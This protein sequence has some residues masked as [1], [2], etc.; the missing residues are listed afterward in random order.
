[1]KKINN[2]NKTK[3]KICN[4]ASRVSKLREKFGWTQ[5]A[6]SH[7]AGIS[8]KTL[9]RLETGDLGIT[10]R[11]ITAVLKV[12]EIEICEQ[13]NNCLEEEQIIN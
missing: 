10:L 11:T 6:L 9:S 1:M 12:F 3:S 7:K 8:R 5:E 4:F 13:C 2:N